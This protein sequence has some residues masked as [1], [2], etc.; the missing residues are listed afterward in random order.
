MWRIAYA[1]QFDLAED[2]PA[3]PA[4]STPIMIGNSSR[5]PPAQRISGQLISMIRTHHCSKFSKNDIPV[6]IDPRGHFA[7]IG[8]QYGSILMFQIP[9]FRGFNFSLG[10]ETSIFS[11][12]VSPDESRIATLIKEDKICLWDRGTRA[13][14]AVI[15]LEKQ[16]SAEKFRHVAFCNG[17]KKLIVSGEKPGTALDLKR[18][19]AKICDIDQGSELARID[20]DYLSVATGRHTVIVCRNGHKLSILDSDFNLLGNL[21]LEGKRIVSAIS[22][23]GKTLALASGDSLISW[24][25]ENSVTLNHFQSS[26]SAEITAIAAGNGQKLA[27]SGFD[28][29]ILI[30]DSQSR[31]AVTR[32]DQKISDQGNY[33]IGSL[34]FSHDEK[35]LAVGEHEGKITLWDLNEERPIHVFSRHLFNITTMRFVNEGKFLVACNRAFRGFAHSPESASNQLIEW[36]VTNAH[37]NLINYLLDNWYLDEIGLL[38]AGFVTR[39][40]ILEARKFGPMNIPSRES[41]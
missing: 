32:I 19:F 4:G 26:I 38:K 33:S 23:N 20:A 14:D 2:S 39:D 10:Q 31:E 3:A 30:F 9:S 5:P 41:H 11:A 21:H 37:P 35:L 8:N 22:E 40:N 6:A 36:D 16:D 13:I 18:E 7:A 34:E 24:D 15:K 28:G 25:L 17:E 1:T 29:S 27:V 12:A